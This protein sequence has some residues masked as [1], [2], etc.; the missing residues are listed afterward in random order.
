MTNKRKVD[1]EEAAAAE[2]HT[3]EEVNEE[4]GIQRRNAEGGEVASPSKR[5]RTDSQ[6]AFAVEEGGALE[7]IQQLL[8]EPVPTID[9]EV[10]DEET[11]APEPT[12][13]EDETT[14]EDEM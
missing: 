2:A 1:G 6:A 13:T 5:A 12:L 3:S 10:D 4:G 8:S 14:T 11:D 7:P 9:V